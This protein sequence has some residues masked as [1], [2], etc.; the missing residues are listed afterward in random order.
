MQFSITRENLIKPLQQ[1]CGVLN[2]RPPTAVLHNLLLQVDNNRLILTGTDLEVELSTQSSLKSAD[3]DGFCTIPGKKF[4]DICRSFSDNAE[5]SVLFEDD[6]AI[7]T[8]GRSKFT[9]ST[10]PANEYPTLTDWHAEVDFTV[11]QETLSRLIDATQFSMA[12]QDA[13]YFLNGMKFETEGNLLRTIATDGHRLAVCTI[14]LEQ[15]LPNHAVIVPRKG[16]L[17]LNRLLN[18]PDQT[19][20]IQI[21]TSNIRVQFEHTVF[22]SKLIDGRFP[23]YR[24]VLPRNADHIIEADWATLKQAF[25]R[26]A[27]LSSD[28]I[29]GVRL[30]LS[31]NQMGITSSNAEKDVAEEVIDIQYDNDEMEISFNV[32]YLIDVLNALKCEKVRFRFSDSNSSCL[33]EDCNEASAEYVIMPMRL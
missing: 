3:Q 29:H 5:I 10:L 9:L 31:L 16:V 14:A 26:A 17:E 28:R 33:L 2:S 7:V 6:R 18:E 24:R 25:S 12:N 22:T 15:S 8:S 32:S 13:R 1:V 23:D 19:V 20:R 4:L 11:Q 27:I 30:A 21:G